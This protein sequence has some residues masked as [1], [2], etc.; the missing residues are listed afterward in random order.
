LWEL[1]T[2]QKEAS[3]GFRATGD[4]ILSAP[5]VSAAAL[6]YTAQRSRLTALLFS[7]KTFVWRLHN[8][9]KLQPVKKTCSCHYTR[10]KYSAGTDK[11]RRYGRSDDIAEVVIAEL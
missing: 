8:R 6:L 5:H 1:C 4:V 11:K 10:T 7:H 2:R 3:S 9:A